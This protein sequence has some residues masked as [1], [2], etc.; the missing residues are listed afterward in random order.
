MIRTAR[1][2]V[3]VVFCDWNLTLIHSSVKTRER[4]TE[5]EREKERETEIEKE[6][7]RETEREREIERLREKEREIEKERERQSTT[8]LYGFFY[9]CLCCLEICLQ[10]T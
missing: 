9:Q 6:R 1:Q 10:K 5:R 7:E 3:L 8:V 4:E 2:T